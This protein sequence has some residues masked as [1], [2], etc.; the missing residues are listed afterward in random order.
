RNMP[1]GI[2][3]S[4]SATSV[5]AAG[6]MIETHGQSYADI[7]KGGI[8][9][10]YRG[11][12]ALAVGNVVDGR[13]T[14]PVGVRMQ[15]PNRIVCTGNQVRDVANDDLLV[16]AN[17]SN[18]VIEGGAVYGNDAAVGFGGSRPI[19]EVRAYGNRNEIIVREGSSGG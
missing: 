3:V 4:S 14:L 17:G 7:L 16:V 8:H 1:Q 13:G 5:L 6:N 12:S 9:F 15:N 10:R 18:N 2:D 19:E 11:L